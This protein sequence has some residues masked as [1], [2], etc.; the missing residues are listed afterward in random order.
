M[1]TP[2]NY[3]IAKN[4]TKNKP[5]RTGE[6]YLVG[7]GF[8]FSRIGNQRAGR[9]ATPGNADVDLAHNHHQSSCAL[10]PQ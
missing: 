6:S 3:N 7:E 8:Y 9:A 10:L 5:P 4:W 1:I 2:I